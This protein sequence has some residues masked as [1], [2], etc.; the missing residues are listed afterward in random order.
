LSMIVRGSIVAIG[1]VMLFGC[2]SDGNSPVAYGGPT[3]AAPAAASP[4]TGQSYTLG[5][6][7]KL[8]VIVFGEDDISGQFELDGNGNFS[9]PLIGQIVAGG[10]TPGQVEAM[11]A[12]KLRQGYLRDPSVSVEVLNYRPFYIHGEVKSAGEYPYANGLTLQ[13]AVAKAGGYTY[14][15]NT[16]TVYIRRANQTT[17]QAY[18]LDRPIEIFPGDTV[19]I[20][21][22]FF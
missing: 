21:E 3:T 8:R 10:Q 4:A 17:E 13:S 19:R 20:P 15:A 18:N 5:S 2:A 12:S 7:D 11:I 22:R 9:M 6:G 1:A 14:R 16:N